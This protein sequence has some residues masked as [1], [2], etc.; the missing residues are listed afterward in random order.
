MTAEDDE[1]MYMGAF[2]PEND[3]LCFTPQILVNNLDKGTVKSITE[4]S[5]LV[6]DECHHTK[7]DTAYN[8]L[9]RKYL[10]EKEL[11]KDN[12]PQVG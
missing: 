8:K 1:S 6:F 7:G 2:I 12:L 4:F 11:K 5:L 9:M 10:V 3:I